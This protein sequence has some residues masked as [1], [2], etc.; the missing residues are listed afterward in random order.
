MT[1]SQNFVCLKSFFHCQPPRFDRA[2]EVAVGYSNVSHLIDG[3]NGPTG[4]KPTE[5]KA[6]GKKSKGKKK[7]PLLSSIPSSTPNTLPPVHCCLTPASCRPSIV[8]AP[9]PT[10][11]LEVPCNEVGPIVSIVRSVGRGRPFH[12]SFGRGC[13]SHPSVGRGR[14]CH[15]SVRP[16]GRIVWPI[17]WG[18]P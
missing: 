8:P 4:Q 9:A 5:R 6:K 2:C 1:S 13:P 11:H 12:P 7:P 10:K 14:P 16:V 15:P 17:S 18:R 3:K